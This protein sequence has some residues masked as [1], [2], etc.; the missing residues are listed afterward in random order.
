MSYPSNYPGKCNICG[1]T[2]KK[3]VPI[4]KKPD[5]ESW[6]ANENCSQKLSEKPQQSVDLAFC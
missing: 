6:C 2:W 4:F 5:W 1:A 3:G